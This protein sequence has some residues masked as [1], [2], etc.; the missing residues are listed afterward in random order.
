MMCKLSVLITMLISTPA[1]TCTDIF[2]NKE[3]YHITARTLDFPLKLYTKNFNAYSWYQKNFQTDINLTKIIHRAFSYYKGYIDVENTT[4]IIVNIDN[5]PKDKLAYWYNKYGYFGR[6]GFIGNTLTDGINTQGVAVSALYLPGSIQPKY[7]PNDKRP[8]LGIYDLSNFVLGM[9]DSTA[10]A[11][12]LIRHYQ[13]VE[14]A[15]LAINGLYIKDIPLHMVI[16]D[17]TGHS[18]V[19]EFLD[20]KTMVYDHAQNV[21]TNAPDY[22]WHLKHL[23][24]YQSLNDQ[25][26]QQNNIFAQYIP[27]YRTIFE[28]AQPEDAGLLGLPGDYTS[29]SRFVRATTLINQL[30]IPKNSND[31]LYH[32]DA[33]LATITV[34]YY[35]ATATLWQSIKDLDHTLI[36]YRD[37]LYYEG[38]EIKPNTLN[39]GFVEYDLKSM[40]FIAQTAEEKNSGITPTDKQDILGVLSINAIPYLNN[41]KNLGFN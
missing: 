10:E 34:P 14:S 35:E 4:N 38:D 3:P 21:L 22:E 19:I 8:A 23:E 25:G 15:M 37:I 5:I 40:S 39:N 36:Y 11:L 12:T 29:A 2:I 41:A 20:G 18:A 16:R 7:N 17:K 1:I 24:H 9:A 27:Q 6:L 28:N 26:D 30:P 33:I 31:A 13:L 32:A